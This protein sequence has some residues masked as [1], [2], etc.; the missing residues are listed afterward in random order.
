MASRYRNSAGYA[1]S[2][3]RAL[4]GAAAIVVSGVG[5]SRADDFQ[6]S[7]TSSPF[8]VQFF[9]YPGAPGLVPQV[10]C[11]SEGRY[12]YDHEESALAGTGTLNT[13]ECDP[14]DVGG[15]LSLEVLGSGSVDAEG[16][17]TLTDTSSF[18]DDILS[19]PEPYQFQYAGAPFTQQ[20]SQIIGD[21]TATS[22]V[23]NLGL[24]QFN[25]PLNTQAYVYVGADN[26]RWME[27][28]QADFPGAVRVGDL[29]L[30]GA[31]DAGMRGLGSKEALSS[32]LANYCDTDVPSFIL[33][34]FSLA[35]MSCSD[36]ANSLLNDQDVQHVLNNASMTQKDS[37]ETM[38]R[39]GIRFFDY[40]PGKLNI[41]GADQKYYH[42]HM[43]I[44]GEKFSDSLASINTFLKNNPKEIAVLHIQPNGITDPF[45]P[46]TETDLDFELRQSITDDVGYRYIRS[47]DALNDLTLDQV[48]A[49]DQ[50]VLVR[51][52]QSSS[53]PEFID[54]YNVN[55]D[56][57]G[58][59]LTSAEEIIQT[60]TKTYQACAGAR[61]Q[62]SQVQRQS[63]RAAGTPGQGDDI[64]TKR[65]LQRVAV[66]QVQDTSTQYIANQALETLGLLE[67]VA[68]DLKV[69]AEVLGAGAVIAGGVASAGVA[70][71]V[72]DTAVIVVGALIVIMKEDISILADPILGL[73]GPIA[74][75]P[76]GSPLLATKPV[77]DY[78]TYRYFQSSEALS[79]ATACPMLQVI[80]NDFVDVAQGDISVALT[81]ARVDAG[82]SPN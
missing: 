71:A 56:A 17:F 39:S 45:T 64:M 43:I 77:F 22:Y 46:I 54:S 30:A 59:S 12:S 16:D 34:L 73:L 76:L 36:I 65:E 50:R 49:S 55:S 15:L 60:V 81:R 79:L 32:A 28:L 41:S 14:N 58:K 25:D 38:M 37:P 35:D 52:S 51:Y 23:A 53:D 11:G 6:L 82:Q 2:V 4:A 21:G 7:N 31:H 13:D 72:A 62:V 70:I 18:L 3:F 5:G 33:D 78:Q 1:L 80:L 27:Q 67:D 44:P 66:L 8:D 9:A 69:P 26:S 19:A 10:D 75:N 61:P 42:I 47:F 29:V 24:A 40:R 74:V 48:V 68:S 63:D 57:Y 20:Y